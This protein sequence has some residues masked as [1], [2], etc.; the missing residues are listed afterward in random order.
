MKVTMQPKKLTARERIVREMTI[1]CRFLSKNKTAGGADD[2]V[3]NKN[4][5]I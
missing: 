1:T 3:N 5:K 4:Y 2:N